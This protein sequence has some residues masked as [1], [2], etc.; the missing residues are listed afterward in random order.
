MPERILL[1][2]D[3]PGIVRLISRALAAEDYDIQSADT[4]ARGLELA[5]AESYD[6]VVLDLRLPD[7]DGVSLLQ[8]ILGVRPDQRVLVLSVMSDVDSRVRCLEIGAADY[9]VKPFTLDEFRARVRARLRHD[10]KPTK[11]ERFLRGGG[12]TLDLAGRT[13][14]T[15]ERSVSLPEREFLLLE[16]LLRHAGDVVSREEL[17][18]EVWGYSFDPGTNVLDVYVGRLRAKLGDVIETVRGVGFALR[19]P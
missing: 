1:I 14:D 12:L 16:Y 9:L 3:E 11:T 7:I 17:L 5:R 19:A 6:L 10:G 4:G 2:D 15:G 13:A 18:G 8:E